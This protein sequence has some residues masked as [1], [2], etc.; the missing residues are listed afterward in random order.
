MRSAVYI[1]PLLLV[2]FS[3]VGCRQKKVAA[4]QAVP[5]NVMEISA[6]RIT[7]NARDT[8]NLG[9]IREGEKV[10]AGIFLK[11]AGDTPFVVENVDSG[12]GCVLFGYSKQPVTPGEGIAVEL[13]FNSAGLYGE[14]MRHAK[15]YTS[16]SQKPYVLVVEATVK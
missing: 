2:V 12:C 4:V 1:L 14:I 15:I 10:T 7:E 5:G 8:I 13:T 9:I 16:F 6:K 11:N 3:G